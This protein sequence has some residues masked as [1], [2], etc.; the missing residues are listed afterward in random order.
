MEWQLNILQGE[1][2]SE[3]MEFKLPTTNLYHANGNVKFTY[4]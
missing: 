1:E 4:L 2:E 3:N